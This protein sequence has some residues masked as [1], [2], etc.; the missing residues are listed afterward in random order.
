[1]KRPSYTLEQLSKAAAPYGV[2]VGKLD[3]FL[4]ELIGKTVVIHVR[5]AALG[6]IGGSTA[7]R[8]WISSGA[9]SFH[10]PKTGSLVRRFPTMTSNI[11]EAIEAAAAEVGSVPTGAL[12]QTDKSF[13]KF[14]LYTAQHGACAYCLEPIKLQDATLDHMTPLSRGGAD[15]A[16]NLCVACIPCNN[17][18]GNMT[19][20]EFMESTVLVAS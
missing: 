19:A 9:E 18:K 4:F 5:V 16:S 12:T 15:Q 17:R 6:V 7:H 10:H 13:L 2:V 14:D 1:M 3:R 8:Y 11:K 20:H